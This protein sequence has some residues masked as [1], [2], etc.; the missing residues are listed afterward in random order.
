[1]PR[2]ALT[3]MFA[4]LGLLPAAVSAADGEVPMAR[5]LDQVADQAARSQLPILLVFTATDCGY[6]KVLERDILRPMVLSGDY[7]D[8]VIVRKVM[9]DDQGELTGLDG[10]KTT[11]AALAAHYGINMTPTMVLVDPHGQ[12]LVKRIRGL[13]V[14]DYFGA[15]VDTAIDNAR[16]QLRTVA[17]SAA[18]R[19]AAAL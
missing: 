16:N 18:P 3:L 7:T 9:I 10:V 14:I 13:G 4:L 19:P 17:I 8:K 15:E 12:E 2:I 11:G 5:H 6:C 1:M